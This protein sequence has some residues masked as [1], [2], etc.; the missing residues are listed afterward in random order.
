MSSFPYLSV[1]GSWSCWSPWSKCS[2]T[3][4]GGHYMRTRTC[5]NPPPAYGGDICLGLH[6]EEALCNIQPC[7]GTH[8]HTLSRAWTQPTWTHT[9]T[10]N[11]K[12]TGNYMIFFFRIGSLCL[13]PAFLSSCLAHKA[14]RRGMKAEEIKMSHFIEKQMVKLRLR[15]EDYMHKLAAGIARGGQDKAIDDRVKP[16]TLIHGKVNGRRELVFKCQSIH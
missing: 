14:A 8:T 3:C 12:P 10:H 7:P 1:D 5:N 15:Y 2:V 4:G 6:T 9:H 16:R 13:V 11:L